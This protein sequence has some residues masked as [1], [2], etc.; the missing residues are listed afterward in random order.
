MLKRR[1]DKCSITQIWE[2]YKK[3]RN[4]VVKL[5]QCLEKISKG[6]DTTVFW[7]NIKT[8]MSKNNT[9]S[10]VNISFGE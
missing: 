7:Q 6:K 1:Y 9:Q 3:Q 8:S 5:K 2:E 4:C 10:D